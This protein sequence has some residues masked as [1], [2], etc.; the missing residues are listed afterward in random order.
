MNKINNISDTF[1]RILVC[2]CLV[3]IYSN[4]KEIIEYCENHQKSLIIQS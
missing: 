4:G 2:G 1:T 3:N